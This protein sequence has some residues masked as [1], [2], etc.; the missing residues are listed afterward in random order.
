MGSVSLGGAALSID[1]VLFLVS[2]AGAMPIALW[3]AAPH[4]RQTA[5]LLLRIVLLGLLAARA[6][7]VY[8]HADVYASAP[9]T[10]AR[11]ADGGFIVFAGF[12]GAIA[13][14]AWYAWRNRAVRHP[15][16][17][18]ITAGLLIWGGGLNVF[19]LFRNDQV[20]LP[21]ISLRTLDDR[22]VA[23]E[24]FT[25]KPI[26]VNFW[27]T[28]CP[29]CRREMPLLSAAQR[30]HPDITFLFPNQ[31]ESA[32]VVTRYLDARAPGLRNVLLDHAGQFPVHVG[33]QALPVTLFFSESGI[34]L[35]KHVGE[36]SEP[37]LEQAI[38]GLKQDSRRNTARPAGVP[39]RSD[40]TPREMPFPP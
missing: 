24:D 21:K 29:P 22:P 33:S 5:F 26:V 15:L 35:G 4:R 40:R 10:A 6:A 19:W 34:M 38:A 13:A 7:H 36:L 16:V 23:I 27:A 8:F 1:L 28:W 12:A 20:L 37:A 18:A 39:G 31:G 17:L 30:R 9:W 2:I 3:A 14:T 11:L 32:G 25:G